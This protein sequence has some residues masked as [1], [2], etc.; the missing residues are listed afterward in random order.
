[1]A[2]TQDD[3]IGVL[4]SHYLGIQEE[5]EEVYVAAHKSYILD[6]LPYTI[7]ILKEAL[8]VATELQIV[9]DKEGKNY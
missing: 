1:M 7:G 9:I 4:T 8:E 6:S 2:G 5:L 3:L